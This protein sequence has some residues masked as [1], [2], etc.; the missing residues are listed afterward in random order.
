[1][2]AETI[3]AGAPVPAADQPPTEEHETVPLGGS[4]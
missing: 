4:R 3:T 2:T 1:M